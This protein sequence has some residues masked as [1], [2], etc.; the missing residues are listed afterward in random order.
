MLWAIYRDLTH[1]ISF[2]SSSRV[3]IIELPHHQ[4]RYAEVYDVVMTLNQELEQADRYWKEAEFSIKG[5]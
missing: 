5:Q 1:N 3:I 2:M 4:F